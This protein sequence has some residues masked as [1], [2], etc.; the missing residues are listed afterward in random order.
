MNRIE[1][2]ECVAGIE[3]TIQDSNVIFLMNFEGLKVSDM[4]NLRRK[5][6]EGE[7]GIKVVKNTLLKRAIS[8]KD[9]EGMSNFLVKPTAIAFSKKDPVMLAKTLVQFAKENP[10]LKIKGGFV[11]GQILDSSGVK[12]ISDL[13]PREVLYSKLLYLMKYPLVGFVR[14]LTGVKLKLVLVLKAIEKG[15]SPS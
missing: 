13:P 7:G 14:T 4:N 12:E 10:N 2:T 1:K 11:E 5:I 15:K 6:K 8:G 3:K 9:M